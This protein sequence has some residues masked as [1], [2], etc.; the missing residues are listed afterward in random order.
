M[1]VCVVIE[2]YNFAFSYHVYRVTAHFPPLA[3]NSLKIV[4]FI[5]EQIALSHLFTH[6]LLADSFCLLAYYSCCLSA[7]ISFFV[8]CCSHTLALLYL[9]R[10]LSSTL[11]LIFYKNWKCLY[12][13]N[14]T[15]IPV[16]YSFPY[17]SA[18]I[19]NKHR[20]GFG[21]DNCELLNRHYVW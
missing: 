5:V 16:L 10:S 4:V 6:L 8:D 9:A 11:T 7:Q 12:V 20:F 2:L 13:E 1:H 19:C 18:F 14:N 17:L 21:S 3:S 15:F